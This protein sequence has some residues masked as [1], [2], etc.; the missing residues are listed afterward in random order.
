MPSYESIVRLLEKLKHFL[1]DFNLFPSIPPSTDPHQLKNQI[2][3]TR[4]F[5]VLLIFSLTIF[6]EYISLVT[7]TKSITVESP[8]V[9]KYS[10][11]YDKYSTTLA[12]P[13][14]KISI[15]YDKILYI[16]YT[17]HEVCSSYFISDA[18]RNNFLKDIYIDLG[19]IIRDFRFTGMYTFQAL[20]GFCDLSEEKISKNLIR[21]Y[22]T[23]YVT[24]SVTP[25][26]TLQTEMEAITRQF[27]SLTIANF[28]LSLSTNQGITRGNILYSAALTNFLLWYGT[29]GIAQV[30]DVFYL[31][32][33]C[34]ASATSVEH[35]QIYETA[36]TSIIFTVPGF[37][38]GCYPIEALLQ[39]TLQC[40][41]DESC[42]QQLQMYLP[43]SSSVQI[44]PLNSSLLI[45]YVDDSP[46]NDILENLMIEQWNVSVMHESYYD[47]CAPAKCMYS[48]ETRND[49]VY[50][51][52]TI[53][54]LVGG[55][56]TVLKFLIPIV[57]KFLR[58]K[59]SLQR[60]MNGSGHMKLRLTYVYHREIEKL[61]R[62][63]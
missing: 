45:N 29:G 18:W 31:N 26:E 59:K 2:I 36:N 5:I 21:Y 44:Q 22:S 32:Q 11:L 41:Y 54:G 19:L 38:T 13:C 7:I 51:V 48:Y 35:A 60:S 33:S 34:D 14:T 4:L 10:E 12:C 56:V 37:Y 50:I 15:G 47:E 46:I 53:F 9:A 30:E 62:N 57:V 24:S 61:F 17:L 25:S 27:K 49:I 20:K 52:T 1:R 28:L 8:P 63:E 3:S 16:N 43:I 39:S 23:Q 40:F 55:L 58:R 42:I 6:I